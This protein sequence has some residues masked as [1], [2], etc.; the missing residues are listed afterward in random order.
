M[1][2]IRE[3]L[4]FGVVGVAATALT[5][6]VYILLAQWINVSLAYTIGYV[7]GFVFN[8]LMTTCFTFQVERNV[9]NGIG[10]AATNLINYALSL[11]LLHVF[12]H[13]GMSKVWAPVPMYAICI[14]VN[15]LLVRWVMKHF[16]KKRHR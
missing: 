13:L 6:G 2:S 9:R 14:P 7:A 15:F 8:Y 3:I 1:S 4:R 5:Y 11:L 12:L 16:S 10:F